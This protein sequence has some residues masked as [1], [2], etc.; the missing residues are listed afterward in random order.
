MHFVKKFVTPPSPADVRELCQC[1]MG[2]S[3]TERILL[4]QST[5]PHPY[6]HNGG[7]THVYG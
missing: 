5:R 1:E 7:R 4:H 2:H 3:R 6:H